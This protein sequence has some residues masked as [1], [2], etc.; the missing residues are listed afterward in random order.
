MEVVPLVEPLAPDASVSGEVL[1][2]VVLHQH[3]SRTRSSAV[4][5]SGSDRST[6]RTCHAAAG[7]CN[8]ISRGNQACV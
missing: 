2:L 5:T 4:R 8:H 6:W 7:V 1:V 3:G